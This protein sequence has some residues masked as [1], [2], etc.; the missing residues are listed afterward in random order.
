M[1]PE[2]LQRRRL[3]QIALTSLVIALV[4]GCADDGYPDEELRSRFLHNLA[5]L[6]NLDGT[7]TLFSSYAGVALVVNVWASWCPPCV[8]EMPS[9]DKLGK[10]FD[11]SALRVIGVSVDNDLNL[12]NEF[13]LRAQLSFP[14]LLD[15]GNAIL[16]IPVFPTTFL[17][18]RD[19]TI[20]R[21]IA[22]E[23]DWVSPEMIEEIET[24]LAVK[25]MRTS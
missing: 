11:A 5:Q 20:A 9:L 10:V 17:L 6:P 12:M 1:M 18:R 19:H 2:S 8:V 7:R 16:R 21:I 4:P 23:R 15:S 14:M 3:L 22:G 24:L 13:L 25:R